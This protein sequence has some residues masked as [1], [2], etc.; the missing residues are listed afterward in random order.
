MALSTY[1]HLALRLREEY[2]YTSIH[3]LGLRG[4]FWGE[5]YL[6]PYFCHYLGVFLLAKV[7]ILFVLKHGRE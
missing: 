2:S 4:L 1:P 5:L 6:L 3:R 7:G